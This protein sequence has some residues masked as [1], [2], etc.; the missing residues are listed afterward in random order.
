LAGLT[1]LSID[2]ESLEIQGLVPTVTVM[3]ANGIVQATE[4]R[5][6]GFGQTQLIV[7]SVSPSQRF[8]IRLSAQG[9]MDSFKTG[10]FALTLT[11]AAPTTPPPLLIETQLTSTKT[12]EEREWYIARP[13]TVRIL[14]VGTIVGFAPAGRSSTHVVRCE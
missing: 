4:T 9:V 7:P 3:G 1:E 6:Q 5:V 13:P 11:L 12:F 2:V 8:I 14:F 10:S